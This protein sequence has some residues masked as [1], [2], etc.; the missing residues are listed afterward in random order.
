MVD[1]HIRKQ[2]NQATLKLTGQIDPAAVEP[3]R[4]QLEE[5]LELG[6]RTILLDLEELDFLYSE[7]LGVMIE[8]ALRLRG[9]DGQ[10]RVVA[11]CERI[12]SLLAICGLTELMCAGAA[13]KAPMAAC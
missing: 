10:L 8:F 2:G 3:F 5:L 1:I 9:Q 6:C 13:L 11:A 12:T 4:Q 7:G